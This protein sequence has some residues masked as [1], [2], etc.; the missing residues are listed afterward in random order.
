MQIVRIYIESYTNINQVSPPDIQPTGQVIVW[1]QYAPP[2]TFGQMQV[3]FCVKP[4]YRPV[5]YQQTSVT[6]HQNNTDDGNNYNNV[7]RFNHG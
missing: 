1:K 7:S 3:V 5:I 4:Y 6:M 2:F